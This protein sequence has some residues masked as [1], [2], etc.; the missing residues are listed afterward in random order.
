MFKTFIADNHCA[1]LGCNYCS[2]H[3]SQTFIVLSSVVINVQDIHR[4]HALC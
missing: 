4:R 2:R 3:L 1:K